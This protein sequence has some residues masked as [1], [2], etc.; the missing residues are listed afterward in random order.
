MWIHKKLWEILKEELKYQ[1]M[2]PVPETCI[3]RSR[4]SWD[5]TWINNEFTFWKISVQGCIFI[6]PTSFYFYGGGNDTLSVAL[7]G[8]SHRP[9]RDT[10]GYGHRI[11]QGNSDLRLGDFSTKLSLSCSQEKEMALL[12]CSCIEDPRD[13]EPGRLHPMGVAESGTTDGWQQ[14]QQHAE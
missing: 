3:Y 4:S 1:T 14:Q 7:P 2:L 5:L 8:K 9:E 6:T 11:I 10:V 12:Q 13:G